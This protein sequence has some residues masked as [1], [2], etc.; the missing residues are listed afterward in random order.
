MSHLKLHALQILLWPL[1]VCFTLPV[2]L[3]P[4][5]PP[6]SLDQNLQETRE[7]LRPEKA[8]VSSNDRTCG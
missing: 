5:L 1:T 4:F 8:L 7:L 3:C 6:P 2:P